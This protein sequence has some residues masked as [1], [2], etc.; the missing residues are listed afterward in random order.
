[1]SIWCVDGERPDL[2]ESADSPAERN[3]RSTLLQT[4][5]FALQSQI[6]ADCQNRDDVF[7]Q[8]SMVETARGNFT[9]QYPQLFYWT[10]GKFASPDI[11]TSVITM[12][13][14]NASLF[15]AMTFGL[16]LLVP[17]HHRASLYFVVVL[18][19]VPLGLFLIPSINP[20][21]WAIIGSLLAFFGT[22]GALQRRGK[23][24]YALWAFAIS[25]LIL[26]AGSRYDGFL[27]ALVG[28]AAAFIIAKQFR[29]PRRIFWPTALSMILVVAVF[30]ALGGVYFFENLVRYA[31]SAGGDPGRSFLGVFATNIAS[32]TD[33]WA[34]FSGA[35]GL[36]WLDTPVPKTAWMTAGVLVWGTLFMRLG[37]LNRSQTFVMLGVTS[38]LIII[39][40][41]TLQAG[42]SVVGENVQSRYIYPLFIVLVS[43]VLFRFQK[44]PEFFYRSQTVVLTLGL[45]VAQTLAL[46]TNMSRYI[47]GIGVGGFSWNLN[48][49]AQLG[50]WWQIGPGP[51]AVLVLSSIGF[52][53]FLANSFFFIRKK[54]T[55]EDYRAELEKTS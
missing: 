3:V 22:A 47:S 40:L 48:E 23:K 9:G 10:M 27:Y 38:L 41:M 18:T 29:I 36:G 16:F 44:D 34:G 31:G 6:S 20:S 13:M 25:G 28:A 37:Q 21:S 5:C 35:T 43:T 19:I 53:L 4:A 52:G 30:L 55:A 1:V 39:P 42:L 54:S 46:Y 45:F 33:L 7:N 49:A 2:C 51:M 26:A 14:F 15:V 12:R 11:A 50:W 32:F 8:L 17:K 24:K